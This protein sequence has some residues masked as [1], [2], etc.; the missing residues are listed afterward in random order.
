[1]KD[2]FI[3]FREIYQQK[4]FQTVW[5][6]FWSRV[7]AKQLLC[8]YLLC[9]FEWQSGSDCNVRS[10]EPTWAKLRVG[11]DS[12]KWRQEIWQ[13]VSP[14]N[15]E[16]HHNGLKSFLLVSAV[17]PSSWLNIHFSYLPQLRC[18][19]QLWQLDMTFVHF[20]Q[21]PVFLSFAKVWVANT[22]MLPHHCTSLLRSLL[23]KELMNKT[24]E[25]AAFFYIF[26]GFPADS[27]F[28]FSL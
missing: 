24:A 26:L 25:K 15:S 12:F 22:E 1:M 3:L 14:N 18:W 11:T 4:G 6:P 13:G 21:S 19:E 23:W 17:H 20:L 8:L 16:G 27:N 9:L 10:E 7:K 2:F 5:K 28:T